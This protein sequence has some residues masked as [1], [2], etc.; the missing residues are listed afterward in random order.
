[1][2]WIICASWPSMRAFQPVEGWQVMAVNNTWQL[3]PWADALYAGDRDWWNLYGMDAM[4]LQGEKWTRDEW[5]ARRYRVQHIRGVMGDGLCTE[6]GAVHLGGNSGY[7]AV[8]LAYHLGAKRIILL[9]FD[10]RHDGKQVHWHPDH[11]TQL[12]APVSHIRAWIRHFEPMAA[13]LKRAGV[14]VVN[15]TPRS[16]LPWFPMMRFNEAIRADW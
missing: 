11:A 4:R 6:P 8:N 5:S 15:A 12:N 3:I 9:G 7:Q 14:K 16:A 10:M 1:M 2:N 13:D